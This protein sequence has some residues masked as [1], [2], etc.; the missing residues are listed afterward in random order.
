MKTRTNMALTDKK[1]TTIIIIKAAATAQQQQQQRQRLIKQK[2]KKT[3][4]DEIIT[5]KLNDL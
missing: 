4:V 2:G 1:G 3:F 5:L